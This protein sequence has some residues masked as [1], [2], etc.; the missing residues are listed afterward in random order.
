MKAR[1]SSETTLTESG[2]FIRKKVRKGTK[3]R[4]KTIRLKKNPEKVILGHI[5]ELEVYTYPYDYPDTVFIGRFPMSVMLER[6]QENS[7]L[8]IRNKIKSY[9]DGAYYSKDG[10]IKATNSRRHTVQRA[11]NTGLDK[12]KKTK[13]NSSHLNLITYKEGSQNGH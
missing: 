13:T 4:Q 5:A 12:R 3:T 2:L 11:Y 7:L 10:R 9:F 6:G 8:S 1:G